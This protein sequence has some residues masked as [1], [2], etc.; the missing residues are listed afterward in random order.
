LLEVAINYSK[1]GHWGTDPFEPLKTLQA[2]SV[3]NTGQELSPS[4]LL[5]HWNHCYKLIQSEP[6]VL[7]SIKQ[8]IAALARIK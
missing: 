3:K 8:D 7:G 6:E 1:Y 4:S 5:V 2:I